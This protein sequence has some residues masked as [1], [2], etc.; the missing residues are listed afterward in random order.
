[1]LFNVQGRSLDQPAAD[2]VG[3]SMERSLLDTL[4]A[5]TEQLHKAGEALAQARGALDEQRDIHRAKHLLMTRGQLS[6]PAAHAQLQQAAM[7]SGR[8]LVEIARHLL[9]THRS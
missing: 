5:Q 4:Q 1:M 2:G 6:E 3:P 9:K 7:Q 8:P